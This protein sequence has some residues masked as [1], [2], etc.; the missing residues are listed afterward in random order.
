MSK[1]NRIPEPVFHRY[2]NCYR[3]GLA[4][5]FSDDKEDA[6]IKTP[7][8]KSVCAALCPVRDICLQYALETQSQYG[9]WGGTTRSERKRIQ[10]YIEE[11]GLT[12]QEWIEQGERIPPPESRVNG[13][14]R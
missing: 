13:H 4:L 1:T 9:V 14:H 5:F 6:R 7:K 12:P 11:N 2:G 8:A 3:T 10:K